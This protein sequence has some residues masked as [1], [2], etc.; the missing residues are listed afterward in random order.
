MSC[1][2]VP[3][4][5]VTTLTEACTDMAER[6]FMREIMRDLVTACKDKRISASSSYSIY[7]SPE[8]RIAPAGKVCVV[9][10][11]MEVLISETGAASPTHQLGEC[12]VLGCCLGDGWVWLHITALLDFWLE[13]H[14]PMLTAMQLQ[15]A[16]SR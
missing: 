13:I 16:R 4:D 3:R 2:K 8:C 14:V 10:S 12:K 15:A 11:G 7:Q 5:M 1:L 9:V 6:S